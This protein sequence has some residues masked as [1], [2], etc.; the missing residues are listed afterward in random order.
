LTP[1]AKPD[2]RVVAPRQA[3][4]RIIRTGFRLVRF[5]PLSTLA[6]PP[7]TSVYRSFL[8][9]RTVFLEFDSHLTE[10]GCQGW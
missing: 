4:T 6:G 7:E 3:R 9:S 1:R 2:L 8:P 5:F 10:N